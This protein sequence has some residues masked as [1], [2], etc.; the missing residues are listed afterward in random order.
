MVGKGLTPGM[1]VS[2]EGHLNFYVL[3]IQYLKTFDRSG[4]GEV[5]ERLNKFRRSGASVNQRTCEPSNS[6]MTLI[7]GVKDFMTFV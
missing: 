1:E 6:T 7:R 3:G 2:F 5:N 4:K